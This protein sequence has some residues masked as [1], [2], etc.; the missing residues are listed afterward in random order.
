MI[1]RFEMRRQLGAAV[2]WAV[3]LLAAALLLTEGF[4]PVFLACRTIVE[5]Y[6]AT[7]PPLLAAAFGFQLDDLFSIDSYMTLVYL[8]EALLG[9]IAVTTAALTVFAREKRQHCADF[10]M[11]RPVSRCAVFLR[12]L[13]CCLTLLVLMDLPCLLA[14]LMSYQHFQGTHRTELLL[15]LL[16]LPLNQLFFLAL[17]AFLAVWLRTVRSPAGLGCG[18]GMGAFL[19]SMLRTMTE[20][21]ALQYLSPLYYFSPL[22]VRQTGGYDPVCA[23]LG[24]ALTLLLG[25]AAFVRYTRQDVTA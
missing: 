6:I 9:A 24:L 4:Y 12:K 19:L 3:S 2:C 22:T 14:Q 21:D 11:T 5:E 7:F 25:A 8:Y 1:Y 10:L 13:L 20:L 16:C 23:V 15:T 18:I 17:G